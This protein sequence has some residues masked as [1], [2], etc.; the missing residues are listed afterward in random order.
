MLESKT[1]PFSFVKAGGL[2]FPQRVPKDL[3]HHY[4]TG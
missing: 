3:D 4:T 1:V 2:Y